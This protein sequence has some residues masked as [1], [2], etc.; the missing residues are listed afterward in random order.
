MARRKK[1]TKKD[2]TLVDL[3][4]VT[5]QAQDFFERNQRVLTIVGAVLILLVGG[6]FAYKYLIQMPKEK[7][8]A[9]QM[10]QAEYQFSLDSFALALTNPGGG[11]EGFLDIIEN[12]KGTKAANISNY[13]A[14]VSYLH[15]GQVDAAIDY[16]SDFRPSGQITPIMKYGV[17]ADAYSEKGDFGNAR[18]NYQKAISMGDNDLLT[19]HYMMKLG[20]LNEK[21]GDTDKALTLYQEIK[22]KYP[23]SVEGRDIEKY[24]ARVN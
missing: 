12:Y 23:N 24:I 7:E 18:S 20:L 2:E 4:E 1:N 21:E 11:F 6:F 15:L 19:A 5:E 14:G 13:Y 22:E 9:E 10:F 17:L 16:L 8:A 3:V